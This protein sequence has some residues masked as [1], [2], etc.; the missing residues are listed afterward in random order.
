L[1]TVALTPRLVDAAPEDSST[2]TS[3]TTAPFKPAQPFAQLELLRFDYRGNSPITERTLIANPVLPLPFPG[4]SRAAL[5]FLY[6]H[7][8]LTES[9]AAQLSIPTGLHRFELGLPM[10]FEWTPTVSLDVDVRGIY[11]SSLDEYRASGWFPSVRVG[12]TWKL[13]DELSLGGAIFWSRGALGFIPVPLGSIYWRP[14]S[15]RFRIDG[16]IPRYAEL[17]AR[18]APSLEAFGMFHWQT[19]VWAVAPRDETPST[20]L[21]RQEIRLQTGLRWAFLGPLR[22]EVSAQWVPVQGTELLDGDSQTFVRGDDFVV[23]TSIVLNTLWSPSK[24]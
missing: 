21:V 17:A 18:V 23:T 6:R 7:D 5:L 24:R 3:T 12:P 4:R 8:V 9:H 2:S 16:L 14:K 13:T 15:G 20:F 22:L 1:S 19:L 11:A 10:S